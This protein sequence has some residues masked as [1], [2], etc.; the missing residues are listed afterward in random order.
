MVIGHEL[1]DVVLRRSARVRDDGRFV[2]EV[3]GRHVVSVLAVALRRLAKWV[4]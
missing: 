4:P 3:S 1:V 2:A